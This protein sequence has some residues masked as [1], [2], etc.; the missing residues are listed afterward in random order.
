ML[1]L[2]NFLSKN[3]YF[4]EEFITWVHLKLQLYC[5]LYFLHNSDIFSYTKTIYHSLTDVLSSIFLGFCRN[6]LQLAFFES[7]CPHNYFCAYLHP[8]ENINLICFLHSHNKKDILVNIQ[9]YLVISLKK[10][11]IPYIMILN[12]VL[13]FI[14]SVTK[15]FHYLPE[16]WTSWNVCELHIFLQNDMQILFAIRPAINWEICKCE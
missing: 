11:D 6:C 1:F 7:N 3:Q 2:L 9:N 15:I 14:Q 4:P 13:S 10:E 12:L 5:K 8:I 16:L